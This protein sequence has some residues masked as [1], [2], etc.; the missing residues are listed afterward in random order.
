[1]AFTI[2]PLAK[3]FHSTN[4]KSYIRCYNTFLSIKEN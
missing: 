1:M 2:E 3:K 4:L